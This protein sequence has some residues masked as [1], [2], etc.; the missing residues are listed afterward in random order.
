MKQ[1]TARCAWVSTALAAALCITAGVRAL[2]DPVS[3][4][5]WTMNLP[6]AVPLPG[7]LYFADTGYYMERSTNGAGLVQ[8]E[9]NLPAF[10]WSTPA[11][12]LGGHVEAIAAVPE[13]SIGD[14]TAGISATS[15]YNAAALIGEVWNL[16]SGWS[17]S[18]F[19]GTFFPVN[20]YNGET[21]GIGGN[22]WTF[23]DLA[24]IAYNG[25]DGWSLGANFTFGVSGDDPAF[26]FQTQPDTVDVDF[27]AIKHINKWELGLVG[28]ASADISSAYR[29]D[30]GM[31][32]Y[33][34]VALG[35][36]VGYTFGTV[37][38]EIFATRSVEARDQAPYLGN[39]S[40][41]LGEYDTRVWGRIVIPLWNP[42]A[43]A[44]PVV[45]KY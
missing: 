16:G 45:A 36:L 41:G 25:A 19:V 13:L 4:A 7:G 33:S 37:T 44:P 5:G 39:S 43:S 8:G 32:P 18:E 21:L 27:S 9:V 40:P 3:P 17:V 26:G 22:F 38:T 12:F 28:N 24:G 31:H 2:A 30:W 6:V 1:S 15:F 11:D 29:N 42:P 23:T 14:H 34:Q 35:G 20:T 10:I